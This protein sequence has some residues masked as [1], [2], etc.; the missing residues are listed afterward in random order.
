MVLVESIEYA[1]VY[2]STPYNIQNVKK[3]RRRSMQTHVRPSLAQE[4]TTNL[5]QCLVKEDLQKDGLSLSKRPVP[6]VG[7]GE[8]KI[9][10]LATAVCGTDKSIYSS[11]KSEGIR[12]EMQRY[13]GG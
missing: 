11:A 8:V 3:L 5:M 6:K 13:S 4:H 12:T 10:V 9:R 1:L 2:T 7:L